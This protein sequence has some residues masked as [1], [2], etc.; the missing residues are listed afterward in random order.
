MPT[1]TRGSTTPSGYS[2]MNSKNISNQAYELVKGILWSRRNFGT[3]RNT[4]HNNYVLID[5][6]NKKVLGFAFM[7][8]PKY[9]AARISLIGTIPGKGYG[10]QI[11]NRIYSNAKANGHKKVIVL[12][13]VGPAQ[14]FYKARGYKH[15]PATSNNTYYGM[16]NKSVSTMSALR[17]KRSASPRKSVSPTSKRRKTPSPNRRNNL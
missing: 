3:Y 16:F 14:N 13:V 7:A 5:N 15:R 12:N 11:M 10:K 6:N 1:I 8:E 2:R 4:S 9:N 17:R